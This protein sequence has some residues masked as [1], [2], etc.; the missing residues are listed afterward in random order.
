[1]TLKQLIA[2][3]GYFTGPGFVLG[4]DKSLDGNVV[5]YSGLAQA[6]AA[7]RNEHDTDPTQFKHLLAEVEVSPGVI[8][9]YKKPGDFQA[10]DDNIGFIVYSF[11][12]EAPSLFK[13]S[14]VRRHYLTGLKN[15]LTWNNQTPGKWTLRSF[16]VRHPGYW[17]LVK[18]A[19]GL[20]IGPYG[21]II[22]AIDFLW[23]VLE[24]KGSS[25]HN[26]DHAKMA[27]YDRKSWLL[28]PII[29]ASVAITRYIYAKKHPRGRIESYEEFFGQNH[30]IV[31]HL[32]NK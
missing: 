27:V 20:P 29:K 24:D 10:H 1:M 14:F 4:K 8:E 17:Q 6:L 25:E 19:L 11:L 31:I 7:E 21:Q 18:A 9:R 5:L 3:L 26:M 13:D 28:H 2:E 22:A 32:R 30:P 15:G 23:T 16:F 12:V